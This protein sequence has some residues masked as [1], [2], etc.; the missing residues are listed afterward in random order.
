MKSNLDLSLQLGYFLYLHNSNLIKNKVRES[1]RFIENGPEIPNEL[2]QHVR[3]RL[4]VFLCGAGVSMRVGLPSFK[5]LTKSVFKDHYT[6]IKTVFAE[7]N[8]FKKKEYDRALRSLEKRSHMPGKVS[9]VRDSVIKK[10]SVS[11]LIDTDDHLNLLKL[12]Q[13]ENNQVRILTTN[14][15]TKFEHAAKNN[16]LSYKSYATKSIP[17]PGGL[18]DKGIFHLHGIIADPDVN[19]ENSE[20]ILTSSDFGDAYLRDGWVPRYIEDRMR[21]GPLILVGYGAEDVAMRLLL[22]TIDTDRSR[23]KDLH[24]I[25]AMYK[26]KKNSSSLWI[27]KGI[28]PIEFKD[29]DT[30]YTTIAEW[31]KYN[32]DPIRL[33]KSEYLLNKLNLIED[34]IK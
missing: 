34:E 16:E 4:A 15:D 14:F 32:S 7:K 11:N 21:I 2:I 27:S 23:F 17:K 25:Y 19:T 10:L 6:D 29:Y 24:K 28:I 18:D 12:S 3:R 1:M 9:T 33:H 13:N 22:E 8:A 31:A 20:L 5:K 26:Y 30:M